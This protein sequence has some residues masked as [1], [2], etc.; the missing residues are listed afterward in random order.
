[1]QQDSSTSECSRAQRIIAVLWPSFLIS[2]ITTTVYFMVFDPREVW[3][4]IGASPL[5]MYT[6]AF[7]VCWAITATSSAL[8]CYFRRP[9]ARV[10]ALAARTPELKSP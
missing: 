3:P 7:F 1:M 10:A 5:G 2:A 6:V 9:C 8:T 4:E